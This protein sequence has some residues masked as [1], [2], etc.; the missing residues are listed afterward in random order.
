MVSKNLNYF[1]LTNDGVSV[2]WSWILVFWFTVLGWLLAQMVITGP[3]PELA[4]AADPNLGVQID[5]ATK[6]MMQQL[7]IKKIS[8][9]GLIFFF[10]NFDNIESA[11]NEIKSLTYFGNLNTTFS[12]ATTISS[13]DTFL[14]FLILS[15]NVISFI[16]YFLSSSNMSLL[17]GLSNTPLASSTLDHSPVNSMFRIKVI[18]FELVPIVALAVPAIWPIGFNAKV[19]TL[20]NKKPNVANAGIENIMNPSNSSFPK[21]K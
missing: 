17:M 12:S 11:R 8:Y 20:L 2:W 14:S 5:K 10:G 3:I 6:N 18:V 13:T 21:N 19:F 4:K 7:D 9:F 16:T 1:K 15:S